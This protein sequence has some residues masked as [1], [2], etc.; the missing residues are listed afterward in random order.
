MEQ[1]KLIFTNFLMASISSIT[2]E[3]QIDYMV[4]KKSTTAEHEPQKCVLT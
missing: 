1:A 2:P 4:G 3:I